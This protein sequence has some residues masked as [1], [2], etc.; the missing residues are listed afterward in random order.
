MIEQLE[1]RLTDMEEDASKA[2]AAAQMAADAAAQEKI[3]VQAFHRRKPARRSLPEHL[4]RERI[5]GR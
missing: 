5:C 2:E 3:E 4:P 1:L